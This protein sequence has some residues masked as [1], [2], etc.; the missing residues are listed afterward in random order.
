[1]THEPPTTAIGRSAQARLAQ[2][3]CADDGAV[4]PVPRPIQVWIVVTL[5]AGAFLTS[6]A[7]AERAGDA[8]TDSSPESTLAMTTS[9]AAPSTSTTTSSTTTS[10]STSTSTTTSTTQ[11]T[12]PSTAPSAPISARLARR[13]PDIPGFS[14]T[15]PPASDVLFRYYDV[16][17]GVEQHHQV[18]TSEDGTEIGRLVVADGTT[19]APSIEPYVE[20]AFGESI[21]LPR[22]TLPIDDGIAVMTTGANAMWIDL[23]GAAV[24]FAALPED[25]VARWSWGSS[26]G[27]LWIVGGSPAAEDYVR[28]LL[29]K[30]I[31]SLDPLDQQGM[32][33]DLFLNTPSIPGYTYYDLQRTDAL[34]AI[35]QMVLRDCFERYYVGYVLPEG[36]PADTQPALYWV[37]FRVAG[38]CAENGFIDDVTEYIASLEGFEA[39]TTGGVEVRRDPNNIFAVHDDLVINLSSQD[40]AVFDEMAPFVEA[41]FAAQP[42]QPA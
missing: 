12:P 11:P 42:F 8:T 10:T 17:A 9:T 35:G 24:I 6:C 20:T 19:L 21:Q 37:I 15:D 4:A 34:A 13:I 18:V 2:R 30:H 40:P 7:S 27:L 22:Q 36:V 26:D 31:S 29:A 23:D 16:P 3:T 32:T 5:V 33:G 14:L 38:A 25:G 28:A 1:M 41:F 39:Q